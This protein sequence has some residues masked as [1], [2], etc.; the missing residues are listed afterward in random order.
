MHVY[1]G[2]CI[3]V[4]HLNHAYNPPAQL[5][6]LRNLAACFYLPCLAWRDTRETYAYAIDRSTANPIYM[7]EYLITDGLTLTGDIQP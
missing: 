2:H 1:I 6:P 4:V 7:P 3:V 5:G